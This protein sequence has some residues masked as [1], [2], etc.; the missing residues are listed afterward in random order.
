VRHHVRPEQAR[1]IAGKA[2]LVFAQAH[3]NQGSG[4]HVNAPI[5][6]LPVKTKL[7]SGA[8]VPACAPRA[9]SS[10]MPILS[11]IRKAQT[12]RILAATRTRCHSG[13]LRRCQAT[14]LTKREYVGP[15]LSSLRFGHQDGLHPGQRL[16]GYPKRESPPDFPLRLF[17]LTRPAGC[18]YRQSAISKTS[19]RIFYPH[20]LDTACVPRHL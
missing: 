17:N 10:A 6:L 3:A 14:Q 18:S 5:A 2:P 20:G 11:Q 16:S 7:L 15:A 4:R 12:E 13:R 19:R 1:V 8:P 9:P